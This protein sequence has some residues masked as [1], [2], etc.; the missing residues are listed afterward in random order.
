[1]HPHLAFVAVTKIK[2]G[3]LRRGNRP[4]L[5]PTSRW[6]SFV[7]PDTY[8]CEWTICEAFECQAISNFCLH[9]GIVLKS[10]LLEMIGTEELG[11]GLQELGW[12]DHVLNIALFACLC[13]CNLKLFQTV[14]MPYLKIRCFSMP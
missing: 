11:Q 13:D 4:T 3:S 5:M 1:M 12:N 14:V 10:A 6:G 7:Y 2:N 8:V 9:S